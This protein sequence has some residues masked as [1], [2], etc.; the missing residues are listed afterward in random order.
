MNRR[1]AI[2][3]ATLALGFALSAPT[4]AGL[5]QGCKSTPE[6]SYKPVFLQVAAWYARTTEI[7]PPPELQPA[8][9]GMSDAG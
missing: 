5:L 3:K 6:L 8:D 4:L 9:A 7:N 2:Q 1:E